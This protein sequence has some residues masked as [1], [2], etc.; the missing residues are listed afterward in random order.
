MP[1]H[2]SIDKIPI[3]GSRVT[4]IEVKAFEVFLFDERRKF[5]IIAEI[6]ESDNIEVGDFVLEYD[7]EDNGN[8]Y[9]SRAILIM[10]S[11]RKI[12]FAINDVDEFVRLNRDIKIGK[13]IN[14]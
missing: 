3:I 1:V 6:G 2:H 11:G 4:S 10:K 14:N 7:I 9:N 13:I 12:K 8:C 5:M